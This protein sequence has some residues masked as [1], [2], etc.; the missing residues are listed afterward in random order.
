ML[1]ELLEWLLTPCPRPVRAMG[2]L[3]EVI[4]IRARRRRCRRA[5]APHLERTRS[6]LRQAAARCPRKRKA[7]I[8]GSGLLLDV[9]LAELA[10]AFREVVLVDVVHPLGGRWRRRHFGNVR[11]LAADVTGTVEAVYRAAHTPGAP[12][13]RSAPDL[14]LDDA[15][16]DLVASVNLLSQLPYVPETYLARAGS[17]SESEIAAFARGLME[18]HLDYL[19]RLPGTVALVADVESLEVDRAGRVVDRVST[20]RG[21]ELPWAGEEWTWELAPRPEADPVYSYHRRVVGIPDVKRA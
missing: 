6:V 13:P 21:L 20:V 8:L 11:A 7:V 15:E 19:P 2:Y 5:W 17:H 9:P 14:F 12:L 16:V 4:A 3:S 1:L 10:A 18:A